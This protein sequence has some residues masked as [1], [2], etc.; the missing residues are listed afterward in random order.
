[1]KKFHLIIDVANCEDCNNCFLACK[2]EFMDN[3]WPGYSAA[4]PRHG[5][6]WMNIFRT[7]RG[8][9]P[10]VEVGFL[11]QPCM[12]CD[13]APCVG[14]GGGAVSKRKDGVVIIDPDKARGN[15]KLVD[16]CPYK[17]IWWN[18]EKQVAQKC[19]GCAHLL[20]SGWKEPRCVQV[21]PT[22]ALRY[23]Y[24]EDSEFSKMIAAEE[25]E[26]YHPEYGT[27]PSVYYKNLH[28][29][30]KCF[31]GGSIAE[32]KNGVEDCVAGA[33]IAI[34]SGSTKI[35]EAVSDTYGEF[36][37]DRLESNSGPYRV[38]ISAYGSVRSIE[39]KSLPGSLNLGVILV[40]QAMEAGSAR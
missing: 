35:G 4:Q 28:R 14:A 32:R 37:V 13:A 31:I 33:K 22:Q 18:E 23:A 29:Y 39:V 2:D 20:D 26:A 16:S 19:T 10:L 11:P 1:M 3:E 27:K 9:Y 30:T 15:K 6:R 38:D 8:S 25:L 40:S 7:E 5:Q 21:C 24:V 34:F 17:A 12:H 36:K